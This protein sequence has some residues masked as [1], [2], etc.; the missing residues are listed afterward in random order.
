MVFKTISSC[1]LCLFCGHKKKMVRYAPSSSH[2]RLPW[3]Q[4][5]SACTSVQA[6]AAGCVNPCDHGSS[7]ARH[8]FGIKSTREHEKR[9]SLIQCSCAKISSSALGCERKTLLG[10]ICGWLFGRSQDTC[11]NEVFRGG[12]QHSA[13]Y[14]VA[15][16]SSLYSLLLCGHLTF[17]LVE[18]WIEAQCLEP[19]ESVLTCRVSLACWVF[20]FTASW[21]LGVGARTNLDSGDM[22]VKS[23]A[24]HFLHFVK[25]NQ[26]D[27][28]VC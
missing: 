9:H 18:V 4:D 14:T 21:G 5:L 13:S 17:L 16:I 6:R 3:N 1:L 26:S 28:F 23:L 11:G 25:T 10:G 27:W 24:F 8:H 2:L 22:G 20:S 12:I 7:A 15:F 19:T